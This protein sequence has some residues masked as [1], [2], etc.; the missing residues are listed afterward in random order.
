MSHIS[1]LISHISSLMSCV[2]CPMSNVQCPMSNLLDHFIPLKTTSTRAWLWSSSYLF[3]TFIIVSNTTGWV[4]FNETNRYYKA[5]RDEQ[6]WEDA[7]A[8]C[9][10]I[11]LNG[12][13]VS[14]KDKATMDFIDDNIDLRE[15][16]KKKDWKEWHRTKR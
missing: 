8:F 7:R 12:D 4:Y 10:R 13:L 5:L 2:S 15:E 6:N 1:Y 11:C 9:Q 3:I 14:I 16:L